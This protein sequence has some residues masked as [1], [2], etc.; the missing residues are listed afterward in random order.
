[1]AWVQ[2][3]RHTSRPSRTALLQVSNDR[4]YPLLV[5]LRRRG[6]GELRRSWAR[7]CPALIW[8]CLYLG[9]DRETAKH[10]IH[11]LAAGDAVVVFVAA[12]VRRRNQMLNTGLAV[13]DGLLTEEAAMPLEEQQALQLFHVA[14]A[15]GSVNAWASRTTLPTWL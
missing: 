9:L 15:S 10:R 7:E 2:K 3:G 11:R 12:T 1:M 14:M 5:G 8:N 6:R 13:G 4:G